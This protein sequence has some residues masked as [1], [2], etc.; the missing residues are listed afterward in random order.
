MSLWYAHPRTRNRLA[1]ADR[2]DDEGGREWTEGAISGCK[3][4]SGEDDIEISLTF[5]GA[6]R[7]EYRNPQ[8]GCG[9]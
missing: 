5:G 8:F 2:G 7:V 3:D 1:I 4:P 6:V 9:A